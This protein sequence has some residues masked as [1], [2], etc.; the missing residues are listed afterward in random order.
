[1]GFVYHASSG[2]E[3]QK[4]QYN[5]HLQSLLLKGIK[6]EQATALL[7]EQGLHFDNISA[8]DDIISFVSHTISEIQ[9]SSV[10]Q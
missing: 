5:A 4:L 8:K 10:D 7:A 9:L 1:M 6:Y 2:L 3:G